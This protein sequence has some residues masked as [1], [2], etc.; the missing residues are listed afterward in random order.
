MLK[1]LRNIATLVSSVLFIPSLGVTFR[2]LRCSGLSDTLPDQS[3]FTGLHAFVSSLVFLTTPIFVALC[4]FTQVV[5]IDRNPLSDMFGA[6]V[7]GRVEAVMIMAKVALVILFNAVVDIAPPGLTFAVCFVTAALWVGLLVKRQPFISPA[8]NDLRSGFG[9][10]FA[11]VTLMAGYVLLAPRRDIGVL[12]MAGLP[13]S[14]G[15]GWYASRT[16]REAVAAAPLKALASWQDVD[17]WARTRIR[18]QARLRTEQRRQ[19]LARTAA[20]KR[21]RGGKGVQEAGPTSTAAHSHAARGKRRGGAGTSTLIAAGGGADASTA[22]GPRGSTL[23]SLIR[24]RLGMTGADNGLLVG[25]GVSGASTLQSAPPSRVRHVSRATSGASGPSSVVSGATSGAGSAVGSAAGSA[26]GMHDSHTDESGGEE[27]GPP[28]M[29]A[30]HSSLVPG[31]GGSSLAVGSRVGSSVVA[32]SRRVTSEA[33]STRQ[34]GHEAPLRTVSVD[35]VLGLLTVQVEQAYAFAARRFPTRGLGLLAAASYYQRLHST[36]YM[37]MVALYN[38]RRVSKASDVAFFVYQRSRQLRETQSAAAAGRGQ[39]TGSSGKNLTVIDRILFDQKW[40]V[41]RDAEMTCLQAQLEMW[42]TLRPHCPELHRL[43]PL[44]MAYWEGL[45][46][47]LEAYRS[48]M[49]MQGNQAKLLKAFGHFLTHFMHDSTRAQQLRNKADTISAALSEAQHHIVEHLVMFKRSEVDIPAEDER[50]A[51]L[52]VDGDKHSIGTLLSVNS[53]ASRMFGRTRQALLGQNLSVLLPP[54]VA[55]SH[56]VF[57]KRY[58]RTGRGCLVNQ[59]FYSFFSD[60]GGNIVPCRVSIAEAPPSDEDHAPSF[61]GLMQRLE[62]QEDYIIFGD[63]ST[64][65]RMLAASVQSHLMMGTSPTQLSEHDI[66]VC[67][68]F[69]QVDFEFART[70]NGTSTFEAG[71]RTSSVGGASLLGRSHSRVDVSMGILPGL[72]DVSSPK[73]GQE[74]GLSMGSEGGGGARESKRDARRGR[75]QERGRAMRRVGS[76]AVGE[77]GRPSAKGAAIKRGFNSK[78]SLVQSVL[79]AAE[80]RGRSNALSLLRGGD[81]RPTPVRAVANSS[82]PRVQACVQTVT[83]PV[84]GTFYLLVWKPVEHTLDAAVSMAEGGRIGTAPERSPPAQPH[85][86]MPA[87]HR[88][89]FGTVSHRISE[90]SEMSSTASP[91]REASSTS[92]AAGFRSKRMSSETGRGPL[93]ELSQGS[94][95]QSAAS[96]GAP[97][98]TLSPPSTASVRRPAGS[99]GVGG[100]VA[101][102]RLGQ[103]HGAS[104]RLDDASEGSPPSPRK[105][106][107]GWEEGLSGG[108]SAA[109]DPVGGTSTRGHTGAQR[110]STAGALHVTS[111]AST[112]AASGGGGAS[113]LGLAAA[114]EGAGDAVRQAVSRRAMPL[115]ATVEGD[116]K[117]SAPAGGGAARTSPQA[118]TDSKGRPPALATSAEDSRD[119]AAST[120]LL[121]RFLLLNQAQVESMTQSSPRSGGPSGSFV[122]MVT[123]PTGTHLYHTFSGLDSGGEGLAPGTHRP[124]MGGADST[125]ADLVDSAASDISSNVGSSLASESDTGFLDEQSEGSD[126]FT[127]ATPPPPEYEAQPAAVVSDLESA[128]G[129]PEAAPDKGTLTSPHTIGSLRNLGSMLQ[130]GDTTSSHTG[131]HGLGW[132]A[133]LSGHRSPPATGRRRA[134]GGKEA[135]GSRTSAIF[136]E[137]MRVLRRLAGTPDMLPDIRLR[138]MH[139]SMTGSFLL[140]TFCL[141]VGLFFQEDYIFGTLFEALDRALVSSAVLAATVSTSGLQAFTVNPTQ[142]GWL[143]T[144]TQ[145]ASISAAVAV[146]Q[147]A[148]ATS[149]QL[150]AVIEGDA[151]WSLGSRFVAGTLSFAEDAARVVTRSRLDVPVSL[152]AELDAGLDPARPVLLEDGAAPRNFTLL[153]ATGWVLSSLREVAF[154][155]PQALVPEAD[156][157]SVL[158]RNGP[159]LA[160]EFSA[161]VVAFSKGYVEYLELYRLFFA[162]VCGSV[163]VVCILAFFITNLQYQWHVDG[164]KR[165]A[166]KHFAQVPKALVASQQRSSKTRLGA[167]IRRQRKEAG[168]DDVEDAAMHKRVGALTLE[169]LKRAGG[170]LARPDH[171]S[172]THGMESG[173]HLTTGSRSGRGGS[174]SYDRRTSAYT[175]AR[176]LTSSSDAERRSRYAS[177]TSMG[178]STR[179][180]STAVASGR[181]RRAQL[182][183][184]AAMAGSSHALLHVS[185]TGEFQ[186][187]TRSC[188]RV[189]QRSMVMLVP[190]TMALI[191]NLVAGDYADTSVGVIQANTLCLQGAVA[192]AGL[193]GAV[194][195]LVQTR[196]EPRSKVEARAMLQY[197]DSAAKELQTLL[198]Q[199]VEGTGDAPGPATATPVP[200]LILSEDPHGVL[201]VLERDMCH[202]YGFRGVGPQLC[203]EF[204]AEV[205]ATGL[206]SLAQAL[207]RQTALLC[208]WAKPIIEATPDGGRVSLNASALAE[209]AERTGNATLAATRSAITLLLRADVP[210]ARVQLFGVAGALA[211]EQAELR[212]GLLDFFRFLAGLGTVAFFLAVY[213]GGGQ[214]RQQARQ[215][216]AMRLLLIAIPKSVAL[217]VRPIL[218][219]YQVFADLNSEIV[220]SQA[221]AGSVDAGAATPSA[222]AAA[223]P[224]GKGVTIGAAGMEATPLM[225]RSTS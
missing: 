8:M 137:G 97:L 204:K 3:C 44:A 37:E 15:L 88:P 54:P 85:S 98:A 69:E 77:S 41:A 141:I 133:P 181:T 83:L 24:N 63:I 23:A 120:G 21:Q 132:D 102:I 60:S 184:L 50:V 124:S 14:F 131:G 105:S 94:R 38:A 205:G 182:G 138:V 217:S 82:L 109:G 178:V 197:A 216:Y 134:K 198:V 81:F 99:P 104:R 107:A 36:R 215:A 62:V 74:H 152:A 222:S 80:R 164:T 66:S 193:T 139:L 112:G 176:N 91:A 214:M 46:T 221:A 43:E 144:S 136:K 49:N 147:N 129:I 113:A 128:V 163:M 89:G 224:R 118:A 10:V 126:L 162:L 110:T 195:D 28:G 79:S 30:T 143:Y 22:V 127:A 53:A 48:M 220:A 185:P 161:F 160:P 26:I 149:A 6:K 45:H 189:M 9:A 225:S 33:G 4:V 155:Q 29:Q 202:R 12:A 92:G 19:G 156:L 208:A 210:F 55:Q 71:P 76:G 218:N 188:L 130:S 101:R 27:A 166:V 201:T 96:T 72:A 40:K 213:V 7:H 157:V 65:Y 47:A 70:L 42:E 108:G 78:V 203:R 64:G 209:E 191:V 68:H 75:G 121:A 187:K 211:G 148:S 57:M 59:T 32:G 123:S 56:D 140:F 169:A 86:T 87:H 95:R 167:A 180:G 177:L 2:W 154:S 5:F 11:W 122:P 171:R 196:F 179:R 158:A 25:G 206:I 58:A 194:H 174:T 170:G 100:S 111:V 165:V 119:G 39:S 16:Y 135:G 125:E 199:V 212:A 52:K 159:R 116:E 223:S 34:E 17:L 186:Y 192:S 151:W 142:G 51:V 20:G 168:E 117:A 1:L 31:S 175:S 145:E 103:R 183:G 200:P 114:R 146:G 84:V 173:R 190:A 73:R 61:L 67:K 172:M 207:Q 35:E 93:G 153:S 219:Q 115:M 106:S 150:A 13:V 90:G 18:L